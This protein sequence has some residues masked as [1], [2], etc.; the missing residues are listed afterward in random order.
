MYSDADRLLSYEVQFSSPLD[1]TY[2]TPVLTVEL[3]L[4]LNIFYGITL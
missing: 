3:L 4:G 2:K 1:R